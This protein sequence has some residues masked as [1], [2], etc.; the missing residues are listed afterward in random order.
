MLTDIDIDNRISKSESDCIIVNLQLA[1][2]V[3][4][5]CV[6]HKEKLKFKI[7]VDDQ[8][9]QDGNLTPLLSSKICFIGVKLLRAFSKPE[10]REI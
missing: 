8:D 6:K 7:F 4:K 1:E 10:I 2:K 3:E 9:V 5:I